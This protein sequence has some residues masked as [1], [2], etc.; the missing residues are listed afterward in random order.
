MDPDTS[1]D[2]VSDAIVVGA[3]FAGLYALHA[4]SA[5]G[6]QVRGFEIGSDVGGTWYWNRYPGARCDVPSIS[7]Q[8]SFDHDLFEGWQW[9]ERYATQPEILRYIRYA[10]DRLGVRRYITF[11]SR[12]IAANWDEEQLLWVVVTDDGNIHRSRFLITATGCL[13]VPYLPPIE[14]I[15]AFGGPIWH[16]GDWP[17]DEVSFNGRKVA[18]IGTGSSAIQILPQ[19]AKDCESVTVFQR[20][21]NFAVPAHNHLFTYE[22]KRQQG[23]LARRY[24]DHLADDPDL[25]LDKFVHGVTGVS[26]MAMSD[27]ERRAVYERFWAIGGGIFLASFNDL[28]KSEHSNETA[29]RFVAEAIRKTVIDEQMANTLVPTDHFIG[30]K[31]ICVEMGYFEAFNKPNVELVDCQTSPIEKVT[32]STIET[33]RQSYDADIIVMA[34][35]FIAMKGAL[36]AMNVRGV[37]GVSLNELWRDDADSYL[38]LAISGFPNLFT[39]TG[40]HSPSVLSNVVSNIEHHVEWIVGCVQWMEQNSL[41]RIEADVEAQ[42]RWVETSAEAAD[43]TLF[44][45]T[46]SWYTSSSAEGGNRRMLPYAGGNRTYRD[47]C[48]DVVERGY[49]GFIVD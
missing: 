43:G 39:V 11:N 13:S 25:T 36:M 5:L 49:I 37:D 47:V 20:T 24:F 35:G 26:A 23:A 44:P 14:G 27:D 29:Q 48:R 33:A 28:L 10:A 21:P 7:Y 17:R 38:G 22:E 30:T 45:R 6:L 19:I 32:A 40:T 9:T 15:D 18:V 34:T 12:V 1:S 46:R 4:L 2:R 16:T 8:F 3:G 31:R 42:K 41:D